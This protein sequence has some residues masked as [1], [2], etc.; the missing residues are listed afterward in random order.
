MEKV[1]NELNKNDKFN[2]IKELKYNNNQYNYKNVLNI[3]LI[4]NQILKFM[5]NLDAKCLSLCSKDIYQLYCN[6]IKKLKLNEDIKEIEIIKLLNKYE[7]VIEL[8]L[9]GCENIKDYSIIS[10]LDKLEKL[11]FRC[12]NISDISFLEN[13]KNIKELKLTGNLFNPLNIK[14]YSIIS[15]L[16]KLEI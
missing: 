16:D 11:N 6:Q 4:L 12:T 8:D 13:N 7:Y 15:K 3:P 9:S 14:D 10:K 5:N 2:N 1:L